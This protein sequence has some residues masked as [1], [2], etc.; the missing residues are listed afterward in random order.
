MF[1]LYLCIFLFQ[2]RSKPVSFKTSGVQIGSN[3]KGNTG[4]NC[5]VHVACSSRS[6]LEVLNETSSF[7]YKTQLNTCMLTISIIVDARQ[8]TT[9]NK[10]S[11]VRFTLSFYL[12]LEKM[13]NVNQNLIVPSTKITSDVASFGRYIRETLSRL[14]NNFHLDFVYIRLYIIKEYRKC[15]VFWTLRL[16]FF[17][18][19]K[20]F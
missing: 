7:H 1:Q 10:K 14:L 15:N 16:I 9:Y 6:D 13:E 18:S 12:H 11:F 17:F 3:A 20:L 4:Q 8:W 2:E 5:S 19:E